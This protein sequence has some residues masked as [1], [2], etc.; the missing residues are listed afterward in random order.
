M[1]Q[2]VATDLD[3]TF[4]H[5]GMT[6]PALNRQTVL[7]ATANGVRFIIASGRQQPAID[8][9]LRQLG[10]CG[11]R[12]CL[13]GAYV[14]DESGQLLAAM[15]VAPA[16]IDRLFDQAKQAGV[17]MMC[18]RAHSVARYDVTNAFAWWTA[19]LVH[20]PDNR[21]FKDRPRLHQLL[22]Q[23]PVYKVGFNSPDHAQLVAL[24]RRL[25]GLGAFEMVWAS[26][27]FLEITAPGVTK[28]SGLMTLAQAWGTEVKQFAAFGDY[29]NDLAMLAGVGL[30]VAMSNALPAVKAA[31]DV[32]VDNA[33][34][35]GVGRMLARLLQAG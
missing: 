22:A 24:A 29:E 28:L 26:A 7:Q 18:Y 4:M 13:N 1:Y 6:I 33:D 27:N 2:A 16:L 3:S 5:H 15:P 10:V 35:A 8:Q 34:H 14:V 17:N 9:V 20:N 32:V 12:V 19:F 11:A 21:L 30:G 31:A 25:Q 23:A